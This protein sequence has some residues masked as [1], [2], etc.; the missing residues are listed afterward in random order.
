MSFILLDGIDFE[1]TLGTSRIMDFLHDYYIS[2]KIMDGMDTR[3]IHG[4]KGS[5][6]MLNLKNS[7][8]N[9]TN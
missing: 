1:M 3:S 6:K 7:R 4:M 2:K 9:A 5:S 8:K